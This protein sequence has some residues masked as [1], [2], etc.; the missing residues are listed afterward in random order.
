MIVFVKHNLFFYIFYAYYFSTEGN[1]KDLKDVARELIHAQKQS[2]GVHNSEPKHL[3]RAPPGS[4]TKM[5]TSRLTWISGEPICVLFPILWGFCA[6]AT[7][8][9]IVPP[10]CFYGSSGSILCNR[11]QRSNRFFPSGARVQSRRRIARRLPV[12]PTRSGVL[13]ILQPIAWH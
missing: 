10:F 13:K 3:Y 6:T 1:R 5:L 4:A 11:C 2:V 7:F 9:A 8:D 12:G